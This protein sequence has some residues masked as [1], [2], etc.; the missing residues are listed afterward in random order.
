MVQCLI[1]MLM[2]EWQALRC[3]L[4]CRQDVSEYAMQ[5][6]QFSY[7][8]LIA[9]YQQMYTRQMAQTAYLLKERGN[10]FV[11]RFQAGQSLL[12]IAEWI[13]LSPTMVARKVLELRL[14]GDR[15]MVTRLLRNPD[16]IEDERLRADVVSCMDCDEHCGPRIDRVREVIGLEYELRLM[17]EVRNLRIEFESENDL[18]ARGSFKTPD[19]LLRVPVAFCGK[20]VCWIDSKAKFA[21]EFYLNKDY[22]DSISS[23]IGRFGP[24][25][26]IY[27][28]GFIEDC[29]S[30][31]LSDSGVLVTDQFPKDIVMLDG[32]CLPAP[33]E[34]VAEP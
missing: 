22:T 11:Q 14:D 23:Y 26:V 7:D 2:K 16:S 1:N 12:D 29:G 17:D 33:Q 5:N 4:Q 30:P 8:T 31:M 20:V 27:W 28:F 24:G 32:T 21:D 10:E 25:M 3:K 13:N 15:K 18:R 34:Q 6:H 9:V 19:I